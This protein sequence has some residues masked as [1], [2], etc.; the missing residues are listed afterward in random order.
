MKTDWWLNLNDF[1]SWMIKD[2]RFWSLMVRTKLRQEFD[3]QNIFSKNLTCAILS[4][5]SRRQWDACGDFVNFENLP[6]QSFGSARWGRGYMCMFLDCAYRIYVCI[7]CFEKKQTCNRK[8]I[9]Y[10]SWK[11]ITMRSGSHCI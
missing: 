10:L 3:G 11:R 2:T 9:I 8:L 6:A 4:A 5:I 1:D 7:L